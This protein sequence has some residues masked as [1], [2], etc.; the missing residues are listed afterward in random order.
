MINEVRPSDR[1]G[2]ALAFLDRALA[3]FRAQG[4]VGSATA[5]PGADPA[6]RSPVKSAAATSVEAALAP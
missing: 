6:E 4:W 5:L 2:D 3:W 1:Q